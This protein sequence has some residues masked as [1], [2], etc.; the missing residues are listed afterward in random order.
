MLKVVLHLHTCFQIT[1]LFVKFLG[2]ISTV[3]FFLG[4]NTKCFFLCAFKVGFDFSYQKKMLDLTL[5][6]YQYNFFY[7]IIKLYI[8]MTLNL[9]DSLII[10]QKSYKI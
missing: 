3:S 8:T 5:I 7:T 9:F 10:P 6:D 1:Q 2:L 4:G